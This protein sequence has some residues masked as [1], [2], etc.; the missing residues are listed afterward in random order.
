MSDQTVTP[1]R[2]RRGAIPTPRHVLAAARAFE[3]P[4]AAPPQFFTRPAQISMWGNDVHG[5]CVTAEEA[6]A[7][8]CHDPEIFITDSEAIGWATGH[9][10]LEGAYLPDVLTWMEHD[11]FRRNGT[12]YDDGGH[13]S[14]D[15]TNPSRLHGA[16]AQGPVKIGV[17]ADQLE[18][19]WL[20][21]GGQNGWFATGFHHDD[22]EDHCTSLC[23]YGTIGWLAAQLGVSVPASVN[24]GAA[25]Y[26]MFTWNSIGIIDHPSMVAITQEAW[27]RHPTTVTV[28]TLQPWP[29]LHQGAGGHPVPTLQHLLNAHGAKL[30]ADGAFGPLTDAA[31]RH[32]QHSAGLA[33]DGIVGPKTWQHVIVTCSLGNHGDAVKGVQ[34]EINYRNLSGNPATYLA[35]DGVFGPKTD[36]AV[37]GFQQ[38]L[39]ADVPTVVVDGVVGPMTW[40]GLVSGMLAG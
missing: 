7:K 20:S 26:A 9:G 38:S 33:V 11:G 28:G 13:S 23:G 25:G 24:A 10:V 1:P 12:V 36:Q 22:N 31:V 27:V 19:A 17:A 8:A 37:R 16:I 3:P 5:D 2:P 32:Y 14:V 29:V 35:V 18:D 39:H 34:V 30:V 4:V 15:W 6:F 40:Q 21:T